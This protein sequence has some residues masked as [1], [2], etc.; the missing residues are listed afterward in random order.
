VWFESN[1]GLAIPATKLKNRGSE[2]PE[3]ATTAS[4]VTSKRPASGKNGQDE[5]GFISPV[6]R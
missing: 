3:D 5:H 1:I 2:R 6:E 4:F